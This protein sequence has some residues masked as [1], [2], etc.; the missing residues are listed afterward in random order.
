[1]LTKLKSVSVFIILMLYY[2]RK[3]YKSDDADFT[4]DVLVPQVWAQI[5][6]NTSIITACIPSL[7]PFLSAIKPGLAIIRI[8]E[9]ELTGPYV[10]RSKRRSKSNTTGSSRVATRF[11]G[12]LSSTKKGNTSLS[13][14]SSSS[15]S[16]FWTEKQKQAIAAMERGHNRPHAGKVESRVE[17]GR[18]ES[19]QGL[20]DDVILHS[21]DYRVEYEDM[22]DDLDFDSFERLQSSHR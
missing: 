11:A 1:V 22:R 13:N 19:I 2:M 15:N 9:H 16:N 17:H 7:K 21:I 3:P 18:S 10:R 8:P 12:R 5:A 14:T 4:W 20:T 6:I